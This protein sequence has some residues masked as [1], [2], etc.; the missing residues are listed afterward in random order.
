MPYLLVRHKV[1]DYDHWKPIFD[2]HAKSRK[3]GGSQ[4]ARVF[5]SADNPNETLILMEWDSL[6]NAR[7]FIG[8]EDLHQAMADARVADRPDAFFLDEVD[9]QPA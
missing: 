6:E 1:E 2:E 8:S 7:K 5:R 9:S 3:S 4:G